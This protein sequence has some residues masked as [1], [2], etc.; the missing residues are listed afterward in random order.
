MVL[1]VGCGLFVASVVCDLRTRR[2]PNSIP[3]A[4]AGSFGLYAILGGAG[5]L[6]GVWLHLGLGAL[7][8]AIGFALYLTGGF[9]AG[10]AKLMAVAG[11]WAGPGDLSAF[12]LGLAAC[13]FILSLFAALPLD[14]SRRLRKELPFAAAIA[15]PILAVMVPRAMAHGALT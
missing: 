6:S 1:C 10:D 4:L 9:G 8:L 13:A 15:P 5:P 12:L 3:V 7:L 14:A 2:I 11:L